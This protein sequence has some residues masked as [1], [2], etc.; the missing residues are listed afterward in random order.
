MVVLF[1]EAWNR[2]WVS[3]NIYCQ[4]KIEGINGLCNQLMTIFSILG[5]T[6]FYFTKDE[7]EHYVEQLEL[8]ALECPG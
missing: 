5:G 4:Y 8:G 1:F 2:Y 7:N 3:L 6:L